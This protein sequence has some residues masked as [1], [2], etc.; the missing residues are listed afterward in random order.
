VLAGRAMF[1]VFIMIMPMTLPVM[2][3]VMAACES[4]TYHHE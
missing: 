3:V 2:V 1:P 4:Q